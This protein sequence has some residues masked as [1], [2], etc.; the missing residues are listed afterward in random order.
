MEQQLSMVTLGVEDLATSRR[1][2]SEGLGW[3]PLLD[4]DEVVFY[5]VG[6]G[7]A[8]ALFPLADLAADTGAPATPGTPFT[9]ARNLGST[10]EVD[11]AVA[12]AR[13]A[14]ANVLKEPQ[15][16]AFGGYHAYFTDPDGHRW[17]IC[18]NPGW[19][20]AEDG[21]VRLAAVDPEK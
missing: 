20:V 19:S 15:R 1:F 9:L 2:Y 17:E 13:E 21:T 14:G 6:K 16:A 12:R 7:V 5:Q 11:A 18:H 8:L 3:T 10:D 4:L